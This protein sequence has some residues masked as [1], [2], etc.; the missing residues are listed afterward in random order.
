MSWRVLTGCLLLAFG[1]CAEPVGEPDTDDEDSDYDPPKSTAGSAGRGG[2]AGTGGMKAVGSA[3]SAGKAPIAGKPAMVGS[4]GA[5]EGGEPGL[6][7]ESGGEP[8][9]TD[10]DPGPTTEVGEL[11]VQYKA[12]NASLNDNQIGPHLRI[13]SQAFAPLELT[14]LSARY[15]FTSEPAPPLTIEMYNAFA[16]GTSGYRALPSGSVI[17]TAHDDFVELTFTAAAGL[18]DAGGQV[19]IEIAIHDTGWVGLFDETNDYSFSATHSA[20]AAW[21]HVTLYDAKALVWGI[22]PP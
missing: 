22:E 7:P 3:G 12:G 1:A 4:G 14:A 6:D 10:P 15:Y 19:T 18:L 13:M 2:S 8:A 16:D 9:T 20:F 11:S 17:A 21:D 5:A